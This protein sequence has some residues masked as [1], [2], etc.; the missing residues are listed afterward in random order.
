MRQALSRLELSAGLLAVLA[1][2]GTQ[3]AHA[4]SFDGLGDLPGG[5]F[6]SDVRDLSCDG[7][8]AVGASLSNFDGASS[9]NKLEAFTWTRSTG[10][11]GLGSLAQGSKKESFAN[12]VSERGKVVVGGTRDAQ[13]FLTEAFRYE[14]GV[15]V[16][17]GFLEPGI[18]KSVAFDVTDDGSCIV[19]SSRKI[20]ETAVM[21]KDGMEPTSLGFGDPELGFLNSRATAV[22]G[23]GNIISGTLGDPALRTEDPDREMAAFRRTEATGI[24]PIGVPPNGDGMDGIVHDM[25]D[26]GFAQVGRSGPVGFRWRPGVAQNGGFDEIP[27]PAGFDATDA[28]GVSKEGDI[29]VG[30]ATGPGGSAAIVW[31]P[32]NG[33]RLLTD[34]LTELGVPF[35]GWSLEEATAVDDA[36]ITVVGNG[37]NPDGYHEAWIARLDAIQGSR[38]AAGAL[39]TCTIVGG[40]RCWGDI[41]DPPED[42]ATSV[43]AADGF[44]FATRANGSVFGWGETGAIG[45]D[46]FGSAFSATQIGAGSGFLCAT[47]AEFVLRCEGDVPEGVEALASREVETFGVGSRHVCIVEKETGKVYCEGEEA[48]PESPSGKLDPDPELVATRVFAGENHSCALEADG[49][50][51]ECFGDNAFGQAPT[52]ADGSFSRGSAGPNHTCLIETAPEEESAF[53]LQCRGSNANGESMPPRETPSGL[54]VYQEVA[55]GGGAQA[56]HTCAI[57][58]NGDIFCRGPF[59]QEDPADTTPASPFAFDQSC[60][61]GRGD[62]PDCDGIP[63]TAYEETT[64]N[65]PAD[66]NPQQIDTDGDGRGDACD[67]CAD[68][69]DNGVDSDEPPDGIPDA[70]DP[71]EEPSTTLCLTDDGTCNPAG[72][73]FVQL[74]ETL[75]GGGASLELRIA[76]VA[77]SVLKAAGVFVVDADTTT[78]TVAPVSDST[79]GSLGCDLGGCPAGAKTAGTLGTNVQETNVETFVIG[80]DA[81]SSERGTLPPQGIGFSFATNDANNPLCDPSGNPDA[82][83]AVVEIDNFDPDDL[84]VFTTA[85]QDT[86]TDDTLVRTTDGAADESEIE[87]RS[88]A[89]GSLNEI[90]IRPAVFDNPD[91]T[92]FE[93]LLE[94]PSP[95]ASAAF[96]FETEGPLR[97]IGCQLNPEMN[98]CSPDLA[99]FTRWDCGSEGMVGSIDPTANGGSYVV[100]PVVNTASGPFCDGEIH[101]S[102]LGT[103]SFA[104][105]LDLLPSLNGDVFTTPGPAL[106]G[107]LETETPTAPRLKFDQLATTVGRDNPTCMPTAV[108]ALVPS[109][110]GSISGG[111]IDKVSRFVP[112]IDPDFDGIATGPDNCRNKA[113]GNQLDLRGRQTSLDPPPGLSPSELQQFQQDPGSFTGANNI[114]LD[115]ECGDLDGDG[116][117][118]AVDRDLLVQLLLGAEPANV[119]PDLGSTE[120]PPSLDAGDVAAFDN[121][122]NG[123][124]SGNEGLCRPALG[125]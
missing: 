95:I 119:D 70:C 8:T 45:D 98:F 16:E 111:E 19:G 25:D 59:D 94:A 58:A 122:L 54:R 124:P 44:A 114:G 107:I 77:T 20:F 89:I 87:F 102:L 101:I 72:G 123:R 88:G 24:V 73:L 48:N 86:V 90:L 104:D 99:G 100:C 49:G 21:W 112:G 14:D 30:K 105:G 121:T 60:G 38:I 22:S 56:S 7:S 12:G 108:S 43:T 1:L 37:I 71:P 110:G 103:E 9:A 40:L 84:P 42:Q 109:L 34:V 51:L 80:L 50:T 69:P 79:G 52:N 92:K 27:P 74:D 10:M 83:L 3:P 17:L 91:G 57:D 41:E 65:C 64:D 55:A 125:L 6:F 18:D 97:F 53:L 11:R 66:L 61:G 96:S 28:L 85:G 118:D 4:G 5:G 2:A 93:V 29:V 67:P 23:D 47:D 106:L 26:D 33:T 116:D 63:N 15:M 76:C 115:C 39:H 32:T 46:P 82:L 75:P 62:D 81:S 113:N 13:G 78:V 68:T 117:A 35:D 31:D 120:G 36:G